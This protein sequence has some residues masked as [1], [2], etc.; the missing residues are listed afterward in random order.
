[1]AAVERCLFLVGAPRSGTKLLRGLLGRHP[2]IGFLPFETGFLPYWQERWRDFGDLADPIRFSM[3]VSRAERLPYFDFRRRD[4][5]P[6]IDAK[7]WH[8]ACRDDFSPEGVFRALARLETNANLKPDLIWADKSPS[9]LGHVA[10]LGCLYP[11][12]KFVHIRRDVRDL[13]LSMQRA[14]GKDPLRAAARWR[15]DLLAVRQAGN[16]LGD[17][18]TEVAYE[19]LLAD[20]ETELRRLCAFLDL[21]FDRAMLTLDRPT[22]NL[23]FTKDRPGI[24]ADN[25][26]RF[27]THL[28]PLVWQRV[29]EIAWPAMLACGYL[30]ERALNAR[31]LPRLHERL[32]RWKDATALVR[33]HVPGRGL[34]P[35]VR[36]V[37]SSVRSSGVAP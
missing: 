18:F 24:V 11:G 34:A 35:S 6:P 2:S 1:M 16:A 8:A 15:R 22:E 20:P 14:W 29:E 17:R 36:F 10:M 7:I 3:F 37:W 12:A 13:A 21:R 5:R 30:P 19:G 23:G 9:H 31:P 32:L 28:D 4:G 33:A 25:A 26:G 27:R